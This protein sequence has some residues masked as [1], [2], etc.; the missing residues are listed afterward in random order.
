MCFLQRTL[1]QFTHNM[2]TTKTSNF[3][4]ESSDEGS[5]LTDPASTRA[6]RHR[7]VLFIGVSGPTG[8]GKSTVAAA[9]AKD[10]DSP[11]RPIGAD[12]FFKFPGSRGFGCCPKHP[13]HTCSEHPDSV[14][15]A[16]L[17]KELQTVKEMLETSPVIP[18]VV[19]NGGSFARGKQTLNVKSKEGSNIGKEF[20]QSPVVVVVEGF[21]LFA[22]KNVTAFLDYCL[23]LDLHCDTGN[24]TMTADF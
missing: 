19:V 4:F 23:F 7:Q 22:D 1:K 21:L 3:N 24:Q 17:L 18:E 9:L 5:V 14:D 15:H 10:F 16:L 8:S 6:S 2:Q 20:G 13:F 11:L 12:F